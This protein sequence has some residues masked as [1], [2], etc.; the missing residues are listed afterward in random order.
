MSHDLPSQGTPS[1]WRHELIHLRSAWWWLLMLGI[2]LT[3]CGILAIVFPACMVTTS[4]VAV[5]VLGVSLMVGGI[6]TI[7]ATFWAG[8]SSGALLHLL[9]GLLY[10]M[11]GFVITE[12]PGASLLALTIFIA[13]SFIVLGA[14][15]SAAALLVRFPQWGWALLNGAI[16]LIL[17]VMIYRHLP[18]DAL[19]VVGLLVGIDML[20][21][22]W[23]WIMLAIV[24]SR[25]P[26]ETV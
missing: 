24:V 9:V 14:F 8:R 11:S 6:S 19:W 7:V 1:T 25:L 2:L 13:A 17:G 21:S 10:L 23:T 12:K 16:T 15:R 26:R 18:Q 22:G 5:I 4:F 3:L 20:F